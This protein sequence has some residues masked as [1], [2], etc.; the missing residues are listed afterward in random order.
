MLYTGVRLFWHL[1]F[2]VCCVLCV[3]DDSEKCGWCSVKIT[4]SDFTK[5]SA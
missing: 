4:D 3:C 5:L 1:L 2:F